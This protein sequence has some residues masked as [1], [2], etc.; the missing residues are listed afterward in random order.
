MN[1]ELLKTMGRWG[2]TLLVVL[3]LFVLSALPF[4]VLS[5]GEIRPMF[6]LMAVYY[7]AI[8]R[9]SLISPL[10]VFIIGLLLDFISAYPLGLNAFVL[11]AAQWLVRGQMKFLQAQPF[12]VVWVGFVI[13]AVT[14]GA[15]QWCTFSLFNLV[16]Y[17][18]QPILLSVLLS[19][20]V[21]PLLTVP[22]A[23]VNKALSDSEQSMQ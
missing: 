13:V 17:S 18:I 20:L 2:L 16:A 6:M 14:S 4:E 7:L 23:I 10:A 12:K 19:S 21:F 15:V 9:P 5:L 11:V 22:L 8:Y 1:D 3:V